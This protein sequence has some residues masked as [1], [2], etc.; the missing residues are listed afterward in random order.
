MTRSEMLKMVVEARRADAA[1]RT[2]WKKRLSSQSV[3]TSVLEVPTCTTKAKTLLS[4]VFTHRV[5]LSLLL[6]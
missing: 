6:F 1:N 3:A 5:A 4:L 2:T